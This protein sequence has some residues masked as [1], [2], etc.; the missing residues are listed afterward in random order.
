MSLLVYTSEGWMDLEEQYIPGCVAAELPDGRAA[1]C[2]AVAVAARTY[3]LRA[4]AEHPILGTEAKPIPNHAKF[5]VF[6][7]TAPTNVREALS[8][9][10]S[11]VARY[12]GEL[13]LCNHVLGAPWDKSGKPI[14]PDMTDTEQWVT[15]NSGKT[16]AAV[17]PSP[18]SNTSRPDNRGCLSARGADWLAAQ[19][20]NYASILRYFYGADL[21]IGPLDVPPPVLGGPAPKPPPQNPQPLPA[22]PTVPVNEP[23]AAP[24]GG[25]SGGFPL[26]ILAVVM[27]LLRAEAE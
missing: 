2:R 25:S 24:S 7:K 14:L 22:G 17:D 4:M 3:V 12:R 9:V 19:G 27:A 23:P 21:Y 16:G 1:A 8:S 20:Y 11:I 18:I 6:Q 5:Q 10:R 13:V 15:H 26:P